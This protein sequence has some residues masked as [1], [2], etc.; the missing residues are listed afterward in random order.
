MFG[1]DAEKLFV[2]LIIGVLVLGPDKLPEY[3]AKLATLIREVR[4]MA[5]GAQEQLREELGPGFEDVDWNRFDPRQYD[6]RRII[7]D[8]LTDEPGSEPSSLGRSSA[9]AAASRTAAAGRLDAGQQ[10]PFDSEAT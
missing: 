3:A 5:A 10:A 4:R 2:L 6:P 8:A 9:P 1:I 7:R